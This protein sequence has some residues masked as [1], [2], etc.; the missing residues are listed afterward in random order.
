MLQFK[1]FLLIFV[2][3]C[4][5]YLFAQNAS[6]AFKDVTTPASPLTQAALNPECQALFGQNYTS[7]YPTAA[8]R[9]FFQWYKDGGD[10]VISP[11][12]VTGTPTGD[13]A[14]CLAFAGAV[15]TNGLVALGPTLCW[16]PSAAVFQATAGVGNTIFGDKVFIRIF[17]APT[18]AAATKSICFT[19]LYT[20]PSS[21][22][23]YVIQPFV[24]S[25]AW[26]S[27]VSYA[28]TPLPNPAVLV[29]PTPSG[30]TGLAYAGQTLSWSAGTGSTPSGY[31]VYFDTVNP[32]VNSWGSQTG[33]VK[34]TGVLLPNQT[35]YWQIV[36]WNNTGDAVGCPVW[37][38]TT[39]PETNPLPAT[40]FDPVH[41]STVYTTSYPYLQTLSW[42][43][44][45]AGQIPTGYKVYIG[46][47]GSGTITPN[48]IINGTTQAHNATAAT[49][50]LQFSVD[51]AGTYYWQI[52]PYYT[53][54]GTRSITYG[55]PVTTRASK[56][57]NNRGEATGCPILSFISALSITA[58]TIQASNVNFSMVMMNQITINWTR[59]N[60]SNCVVF[61]KEVTIGVPGNPTDGNTYSA[62]TNWSSQGTQ[63]G[64]TGYFCVYNGTGG[65]VTLTN[66]LSSTNYYA[67]VFEYNGT[68]Q[69]TKYKAVGAT[70][71]TTTLTPTPTINVT[72]SLNDFGSVKVGNVSTQQSYTVSAVNLIANLAIKAPA[73]FQISLIENR[74]TI[75]DSLNLTPS[76]GTISPTTIFV[77]FRPN[78]AGVISGNITH[79]STGATPWD[80][81]V[82]GTGIDNPV[83]STPTS[84]AITSTTATL[85]GTISNINLS[86]VSE[87]GIYYSTT[88]GFANGTGTKVSETAGA[89]YGT[90]SF[91]IPVTGL[92]AGTTYYFK[93]F[94]T[95]AAGTSYS[96]QGSFGTPI[97]IGGTGV[98]PN[99]GSV[100]IG[101]A[102]P[103]QFYITSGINLQSDLVITAPTGF[104]V[105]TSS[106]TGFGSSVI[107]IPVGGTINTTNIYVKFT[108]STLG[109]IN[110]NV[111]STSTG[112]TTGNLFVSGTGINI[113]VLVSPTH[114]SV[115]TN[116]VLLGGN[117]NNVNYSNATERG[118]YYSTTDG[119][120][121]GTGTKVSETGSFGAGV[122]FINVSGLT[123]NTP[124][125]FKVFATNEAGTGYTAQSSFTTQAQYYTVDITSSPSDADIFINGTDSGF[126]T[127]RQF[128]LMEGSNA[129]YKVQKAGYT[130]SPDSLVV[131]NIQAD[132]SQVFTGTLL[133]YTVDIT[134]SPSGVVIYVDGESTDEVTPHQFVMNYGTSAVYSVVSA[135]YTW[136][137][138]NIAVNNIQASTSQH[139]VGTAGTYYVE[140]TSDPSG[141]DI[142]FNNHD[143][144]VNTPYIFSL[145][146]GTTVDVSV[147]KAGY[148][149]NPGSLGID[150]LQAN[151]TQNFIGT[152]IPYDVLIESIP[153]NA[154]I[155]VD[156]IDSGHHTP[157]TFSMN[158]NTSATY[159][160]QMAGYTWEPSS[161]DVNNIQA[162]TN[163]LFTGTLLTYSVEITSE[164]IGAE[165]FVLLSRTDDGRIISDGD[166]SF[167]TPH[168][169]TLNYGSTI[170][171]YVQIPG[172]T[173]APEYATVSNIQSDTSRHFI[174][175]IITYPVEITST[176]LGADIYIDGSDSGQNTPY[177][178]TM[179]YG[180]GATYTVQ[181][182]G[183][184]FE[185]DSLVVT[186]IQG[187]KNQEFT[188]T[189]ITYTVLITST[190]T[191]AYIYKDGQYSGYD[192]PYTFTMNYGTSATY[193]VH[194][195]GYSWSPN[196]LV[197]NNIQEN[198]S[199]E[200]TGSV[201]TY[202][203]ELT[204][205]PSGA[206]I[207]SSTGRNVY[208]D[209]G[210]TTPT[211]FVLDYHTS[212]S[213]RVEKPGYTYTPDPFT[214]TNIEAGTSQNFAG[215]I[216]TYNVDINSDPAGAMIYAD[217]ISTGQVTPHTFIMEYNTSAIYTVQ[218]DGYSFGPDN[219]VVSN[220]QENTGQFFEGTIL[221]YTVTINSTPPGAEI[222]SLD[223]NAIELR[224]DSYTDT[225]HITPYEFEVNYGSSYSYYVQMPGYTWSPE[226]FDATNIQSNLTQ[227]FFG[228]IIT[229]TVNVTS[230]PG[231]ADIYIDGV[232][233]GQNT[234]HIFTLNYG[235]EVEYT[236][237]KAG[238]TNWEPSSHYIA[239]LTENENVNFAGTIIT[240]TVSINSTP[241]DADIY[242]DGQDSGFNTPYLF[243]M[244][245]GTS[246]TY[247]V[248]KTGY[249]WA[250][251]DLVVNNIQDNI[252]Q[253]FNG[254]LIPYTVHID[255]TPSDADIYIDGVDSGHNTPYNFTMLH[256]SSAIYTVQK[257]GYTWQPANFEVNNITGN[258]SQQF[259]GTIIRYN[260]NI[261]SEPSDADIFVNN[262]DTGYNTPH[263]FVMNYGT[264]AT[265]KVQKMGY[266][267]VP[268]SF[269]VSN[270]Q[271][272]TSQNFTGTWIT[273]TVDIN[274]SPSGASIYED[275]L[276]TGYDTPHQFILAQ[277]AGAV[278]T[279]QMAGYSFSPNSF[280]VTNIQANTGQN[281]TGT[282]LTYVVNITSNPSNSRIYIYGEDT[283]FNTP[284]PFIMEYGS[285]A[286]YTVQ[287]D[288]YWWAPDNYEVNNI[289]A[290]ASQN[291]VGTLFTYT[292]DITS[293]PPDADIYV[294]GQDSG[295]N[296][297]HPFTM[298]YGSNATYTVQKAGYTWSP[299]SLVI[300]DIREDD[301]QLFTGTLIPYTVDIYSTPSDADIYIGGIDTGFN[302]PHQFI[303]NY[304]TSAT[305]TLQ[306]A[307]Y[308][309]APSSYIVT[310]IQANTIKNFVGSIIT[311]S[312][313]IT[314]TPA[315]ADILVGGVDSGYNT[316]HIF[317]QAYGSDATYSVS[318][319][320]YTFAPDN[321]VVTNI[322]ANTAQNFN[323]TIH[324]FTVDIT[325]DPS[326]SDIFV[327]GLDS[328]FNTPHQFVMNY[329]TSAVYTVQRPGYAW[330]PISFNVA[331]IQANVS[332]H[333]IGSQITYSVDITSTPSNADVYVGNEDT[334]LNTPCQLILPQGAS[335]TIKVKNIDYRWTPEMLVIN[336]IQNN[337]SQHFEG[338]LLT[339]TVD[340]SS[341]PA[342][343]DIFVDGQDS[344]FNTPHQ[345]TMNSGTNAIYSLQ[346]TGYNWTPSIN[347]VYS[348]HSNK[349][350]TFNG[351]LVDLT[352]DVTSNPPDADIYIDGVDTGFN[353]PHQFSMS[354][355]AYALYSV[356]KAGIIWSPQSNLV[357][358][359]SENVAMNFDGTMIT[360]T[361]D[362]TS[363]P[364]DADI[365]I[366]GIDTGFN[367][368]YQFV[369]NYGS[370]AILTVQKVGYVWSPASFTISDLQANTEQAFIG[371][372]QTYTVDI[373]SSPLNANILIGGVDSGE[374]TPH[375]F[376]INHGESVTYSLQLAGYTWSPASFV[377]TNA[378]A[379]TSRHF[380]GTQ[381]TLT[382]TPSNQNVSNQAGATSFNVNSNLTWTVTESV[383]WLSA[384]P[385]SNVNNGTI[386]VAYDVNPTPEARV[387]TITVSGG[388]MVRTITVTQAA[389][390]PIL[391]VSPSTQN[392][393]SLSGSVTF[394]VTSN[395]AWTISESVI[396]LSVSPQSGSNNGNFTVSYDA[397]LART[398]RTGQITISANGF[399]R[400]VTVVQEAAPASMTVTPSLQNVGHQAGTTSFAV[401][402]NVIWTVSESVSWL[403]V[404]PGSG[405][406]NGN[407]I[408][409]YNAN[410][411]NASR[412]GQIT[413]S[414][415][416][417]SQTIT[418]T[419]AATPA[420][421]TVNPMIQN[422][423][424]HPGI[425]SYAITSNTAWTI[426]ES[427][428]WLSVNTGSGNLNGTFRVTYDANTVLSPR[429]GYI[430]IAWGT[431]VDTVRVV[432]SAGVGTEDPTLVP[433]ASINVYPNPFTTSAN[434][435]L[436]VTDNRNATL[437]VYS[438]KGE[439]VRTLGVFAKG[440]YTIAWDGKDTS[441]KACSN[442]FYFIRYKSSDLNKTVKVLLM[443]N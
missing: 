276:D 227:T 208:V 403:S 396:W 277:S 47:D 153:T 321:F 234:P 419:Q 282:I 360:Y 236:V 323:G 286:I 26:S 324:T 125:Y 29:A 69:Y 263:T 222:Y 112:A 129:T 226:S 235:S 136:A 76:S 8:N 97:I 410:T 107:L 434:I 247:T 270:I 210:F 265:Y 200:F 254:S 177:T 296:T 345:F 132:T 307:G 442:G 238:Y 221:T 322:L 229:Y 436:D 92:T 213:Y 312:V 308:T 124:Y 233:S 355:G 299:Q 288:G 88:D 415:S 95:N 370:N 178:F 37:S 5:G 163:Q 275:G 334:G 320:G 212:V 75:M 284:H 408:V 431:T 349:I 443:R 128:S 151:T 368:P 315:G 1:Y 39:R 269:V 441:G 237:Q 13:D 202:N 192:T 45:P 257:A 87:R 220:I 341:V 262:Q 289:Q 16:T 118:I 74:P 409:T 348:I 243:Y 290:N 433:V 121:D 82:S 253:D 162:N 333:F 279:V 181:K 332:R 401:A 352:V 414:G 57:S 305:Y 338:T 359:I 303:M 293:N 66:L 281:F 248:Q 127:P 191:N 331:N 211:T 342:D 354:Y 52:V 326:G 24:P 256:G 245:Y 390:E 336:N 60:G 225:G 406:N 363:V 122:F 300:T 218:M 117:I 273:Y 51:A 232:D 77:S 339:Y 385:L 264:N 174:G 407:L 169:F 180:T 302:T 372:V 3:L 297:P 70:G 133:T 219:F 207:Y 367:T 152:L 362:V 395:L 56:S 404:S 6:V 306:K 176:P 109:A 170:T 260:V 271:A 189:I 379:N 428:S 4:A 28:S 283:G 98:L 165:I 64:S 224:V 343:A 90:G 255:S 99:F 429:T 427:E 83:I 145:P 33:T 412:S 36:P 11:L 164:P 313:N 205:N 146:L 376:T 175:S 195:P 58:P 111:V 392:V 365:Y 246:N 251:S 374:V 217:G 437:A 413:V 188:G 391:I 96:G 172:Y 48:N 250:P 402:A 440:S 388:N 159:T 239:Y 59:G 160:V 68:G 22:G 62:S 381:L 173:W 12:S 30:V 423:S 187:A 54:P 298:S 329:G 41:S 108:P 405:S 287:K 278:Y 261:T 183:F 140:I 241:S 113:P 268:N 44:D 154:V 266:S 230:N 347:E 79:T 295:F 155:L 424:N 182:A 65:S 309:Y 240:Y 134:S 304:G 311:Y 292:V 157:Y 166:T 216:N 106:E 196:N 32:P 193:Q 373:T 425:V 317:S 161:F 110:G 115:T 104:Q 380:T 228:T 15:N 400:N 100:K 185:P 91:T 40:A 377:V 335:A 63:L 369:M 38:F 272:N 55:N 384:L 27:W 386:S 350:L 156:G 204:S 158:Y 316:P 14:V 9:W 142:Y 274:S 190:P 50:S 242:I 105:S 417:V 67:T 94:A 357:E 126:N 131:T 103:A 71:S 394:A 358:G 366:D 280:N 356:Q 231:D 318:K 197:V 382:V 330:S 328:G 148:T 337:M 432:Q 421:L 291:F 344:G 199:Q 351:E 201:L 19:A 301:G 85:G 149:W 53:D 18:I 319:A 194:I 135:G 371:S 35:Y 42:E 2:L 378:Q 411:V 258:E 171:Y 252:Y 422:V 375:Q 141:A 310:N 346:K 393:T 102:S 7:S 203:V 101:S 267:W 61:V 399:V 430:A 120:A 209:T 43:A 20:I 147:R 25:Y 116:S 364:T 294:N 325:S 114:A 186:N 72:A 150:S 214:V 89:P 353:T 119:F 86:S 383:D 198:K 143:Q 314:S 223:L 340:V 426:T 34:P 184:T 139:F 206:S 215:T 327:N 46:T 387:G 435:K 49:Q 17:N 420:V 130:F 78:T 31:S 167:Q 397:N 168:T 81:T 73:G 144:D 389:G 84:A 418:V 93:A 23:N 179:N 439:L 21:T 416:G 137:P 80:V 138:V 10:N 244:N 438:T 259:A 123:S 398:A 249:N 361:V 285:S